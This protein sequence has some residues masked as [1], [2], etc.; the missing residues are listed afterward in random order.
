MRKVLSSITG[1]CNWTQC[2]QRL[3]TVVTFL[4]SCVAQEISRGDGSPLA[5]AY[6]R[7]C[8]DDLM[9][10]ILKDESATAAV[11]YLTAQMAEW[12]NSSD[13]RVV[14]SVCLLSCRLGF[15]S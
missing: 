7:E 15:D 10:L 12:Y 4:R 5:S 2:G 9:F 1:Q 14:W 3:A 11:V 8:N 6:C 13:A